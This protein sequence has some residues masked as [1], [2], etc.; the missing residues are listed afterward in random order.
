MAATLAK[1]DNSAFKV[2]RLGTGSKPTSN[3]KAVSCLA[4]SLSSEKNGNIVYF[5]F[6]ECLKVSFFIHHCNQQ[7]CFGN[8]QNSFTRKSLRLNSDLAPKIWSVTSFD[9]ASGCNLI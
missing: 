8:Y 2:S 9:V 1:H 7:S 4:E 3:C 5:L 6:G